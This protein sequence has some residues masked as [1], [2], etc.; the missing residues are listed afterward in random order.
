MSVIK[1]EIIELKA[2]EILV[3][4]DQ[5]SSALYIIKEGQLEAYK[6]KDGK[7]IPL[8]LINSGEYVGEMS[9]LRNTSYT[10]SVVALTP[11]KAIRLQK[12]AIEKQLEQAPKWLVAL[13]RGLVARLDL[14]NDIL[15]RNG[16]EDE[17][18]SSAIKAIE[19]KNPIEE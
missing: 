7:R 4:E 9:L 13:T 15:K 14:A 19:E 11:V 3:K 16:I 1:Q 17:K 10:N 6:E 5:P 18:M 12:T 2:G 8:G